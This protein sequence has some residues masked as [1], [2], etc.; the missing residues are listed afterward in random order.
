MKS[1]ISF[2]EKSGVKPDFFVLIE[3]IPLSQQFSFPQMTRTD[4]L[5]NIIRKPRYAMKIHLMMG[6]TALTLLTACGGGG[7]DA[8]N[9]LPIDQS[10]VDQ[11][12]TPTPQANQNNNDVTISDITLPPHR[13]AELPAVI[14]EKL[15]E[16]LTLT[17]K[18]RAEKGLPALK[19]DQ[20][21]AAYATVR[22]NELAT[23]TAHKRPNGQNPLDS[24]LFAVDGAVAE[25]FAAGKPSATE[26]VND[27]WRNSPHHY[28][29]ITSTDFDKIGIG[30]YYTPTGE[31]RH[32][33]AQIFGANKVRSI[34]SFITPLTRA[35]ALTAVQNS[36]TYAA[37][38]QLTIQGNRDTNA[39]LAGKNGIHSAPYSININQEHRLVLRPHQQA[40]WSYQTF[41]EI[42]DSSGIPE[43]Y[44]NVG[45]PYIPTDNTN[46]HAEYRGNAIGDFGQHS[47]VIADV[48]AH[49]DFSG[50]NKKMTLSLS[51][52]Q[53]GNLNDSG[54][55][56]DARFD[57][58]DNLSWNS[59]AQQF[60]SDSGNARLYG[61]DGEELGGQFTRTVAKETY[62]GAYG[63]KR[64]P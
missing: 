58:Q 47:R 4:T 41:G 55:R 49:V 18:L 57:F 5:G 56:R 60:Q 59:N 44:V 39:A 31:Y 14:Q 6:T 10:S 63:A 37:G 1:A 27:Q 17:N 34:Y 62:H 45:K 64:V 38:N 53:S 3:T 9:N 52:S 2:N 30:Y 15:D 13:V 43:A 7:N 26:A 46:L 29:T 36:A 22:A 11:P 16:A 54:L 21:L 50:D 48:S 20:S 51:N 23:L 32:Y 19:L 28:A 42:T 24:S 8:S 12:V 35:S 40:G 25:N 61:P 33:W